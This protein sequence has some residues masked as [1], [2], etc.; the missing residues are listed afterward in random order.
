MSLIGKFFYMGF[1][2]KLLLG[3]LVAPDYAYVYTYLD[4]WIFSYLHELNFLFRYELLRITS[5]PLDRREPLRSDQ[6]R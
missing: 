5:P 4:I 2:R 3:I 1:F 6:I